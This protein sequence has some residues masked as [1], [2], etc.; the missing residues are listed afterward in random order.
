MLELM[1]YQTN[2]ALDPLLTVARGLP[3]V[4]GH[5]VPS[6][7]IRAGRVMTTQRFTSCRE[8]SDAARPSASVD[9]KTV[10]ETACVKVVRQFFASFEK[11]RWDDPTDPIQPDQVLQWLSDDVDWWIPDDEAGNFGRM[12]KER[13]RGI[14]AALAA[15]ADGPLVVKPIGWTV[16]GNRVAV[17]AEGHLKLKNGRSYSNKYHHVFIVENGRITKL[18]EYCDTLAVSRAFGLV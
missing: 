5:D 16:D 18:T 3:E 13:Y 2:V 1:G 7:L 4:V 15:H 8:E 6:Q 9:P 10:L 17:E 11:G 12:T 14:L